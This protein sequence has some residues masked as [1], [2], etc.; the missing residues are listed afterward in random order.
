MTKSNSKG[1]EDLRESQEVML[2]LDP[3]RLETPPLTAVLALVGETKVES[4][5]LEYPAIVEMV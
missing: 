5:S 2:L 1:Q 4:F 3:L